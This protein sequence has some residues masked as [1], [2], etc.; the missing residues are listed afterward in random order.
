[1]NSKLQKKCAVSGQYKNKQPYFRQESL[2]LFVLFATFITC[3]FYSIINIVFKYH[4]NFISIG[5]AEAVA[6]LL[7]LAVIIFYLIT[8]NIAVTTNIT[9]FILTATMLA[10]FALA[11]KNNY[12]FYWMCIYPPV[13]YFLLDGKRAN[14]VVGLFCI[15]ML[16]FMMSQYAK[17]DD[18][19]SKVACIVNISG[20]T[21]VL[22]FVIGYFETCRAEAVKALREKNEELEGLIV[23]DYLTGLYNRIK[24]DEVLSANIKKAAAGFETFSIVMGDLDNFKSINDKYGHMAGDSVLVDVAHALKEGCH[25]IGLV[26]RWGGEE[27]LIVCDRMDKRMA[28][29]LCNKLLSCV[30]SCKYIFEEKIT[31]S[32]GVAEYL[33]GDT[34]D[35]LLKRADNALYRAKENGK[36][37]IEII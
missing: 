13:V 31:I 14:L 6:A 33:K 21:L 7:A 17:W 35:S 5:I 16:V 36:C 1:M 9:V 37:R 32:F 28:A 34:L 19:D 29:G 18:Q 4:K 10:F 2:L 15:Y 8:K 27:F 20:A 25:E 23:T 12:A 3:S 30:L 11:G 24:L 26:G 22:V